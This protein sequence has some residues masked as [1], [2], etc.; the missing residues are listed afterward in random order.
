M[1]IEKG[2]EKSNHCL[3]CKDSKSFASVGIIVNVTKPKTKPS[4][5]INKIYNT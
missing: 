1:K 2:D 4:F 3:H 5:L